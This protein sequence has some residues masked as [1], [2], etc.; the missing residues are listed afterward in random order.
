MQDLTLIKKRKYF[1][2]YGFVKINNLLSASEIKIIKKD[3]EDFKDKQQN[4]LSGKDINFTN[5]GS[6][7][8]IHTMDSWKWTKKIQNDKRL[9]N[10][11]EVFLREKPDNY[12]AELFAKPAKTGMA[13]PPHQDN[14]YWGINDANAITVWIA[15]NKSDKKNGGVFYYKGSNHL[16]L[17]EHKPSFAPGSSQTI[18]YPEGMKF[19]EKKIPSLKPGDCI[20]HNVLVVHGGEKNLSNMPR[21]GWTI[22]Y[23]SKKSYRDTKIADNHK[24]DL[25]MQLKKRNNARI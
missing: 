6:I 24:K 13:S 8:S 23:K 21:V 11:A 1:E 14:F 17:L 19:F 16:G 18:K 25:A 7:N 10:L 12:G 15:L 4:I 3:L 22:R 20:I 5:D 9:K 2:K